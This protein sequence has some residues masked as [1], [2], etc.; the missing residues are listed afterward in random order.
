MSE[1]KLIFIKVYINFHLPLN[2]MIAQN[3][4]LINNMFI[5]IYL[6]IQIKKILTFLLLKELFEVICV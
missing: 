4:V 1:N 3:Q 2:L 5:T 6:D